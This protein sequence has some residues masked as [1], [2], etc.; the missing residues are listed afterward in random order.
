MELKPI[1]NFPG[2]SI[3]KDGRVWSEKRNKWKKLFFV[4]S[5][6][7]V[8]LCS[9]TTKTYR[10]YHPVGRLVLETFVGPCP[11]G[12]ECRHLDGSKANN[13]LTNLA[14]GTHHENIQDAKRH[15]AFARGTM[16]G[17]KLTDEQ[18]AEIRQ[19]LVSGETVKSLMQRYQV[20]CTTIYHIKNRE[21]HYKEA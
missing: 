11:P 9:F 18:A 5:Y 4:W 20:S 3:T 10:T 1:P 16:G 19:A 21:T 14:W 12:Q 15:G 7:Q 6:L 8:E 17:N 13:N 2:Y